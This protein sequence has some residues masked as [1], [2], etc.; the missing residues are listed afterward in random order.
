MKIVSKTT[1]TASQL[2]AGIDRGEL[3]TLSEYFQGK[4]IK[5]SRIQED[6]HHKIQMEESDDEDDVD[7][8]DSRDN[9]R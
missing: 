7:D 2:F 3:D 4:K 8:D 1:K 9:K 6:V 5:V